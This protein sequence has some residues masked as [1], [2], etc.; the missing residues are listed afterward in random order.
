MGTTANER[1]RV[2]YAAVICA[3]VDALQVAGDCDA[4]ELVAAMGCKLELA[5]LAGRVSRAA[6]D[7]YTWSVGAVSLSAGRLLSAPGKMPG[8]SFS[9]PA[10]QSCPGAAVA[11]RDAERDGVGDETTCVVCY[12]KGGFYTFKSTREALAARF[13]FVRESLRVDAGATFVAAMVV[14]IACEVAR[15]G[16]PCFRV[17]DAGDVYSAAYAACWARV[18]RALPGVRFWVP[19]R[20]YVRPV[21]RA[22]MRDLA[23]LANVAVRPSAIFRDGSVPDLTREGFAPG[24]GVAPSVDA[25]RP[26]T[27]I[28]PATVAGNTPTCEANGCRMCWAKDGAP[29]QGFPWTARALPVV[30]IAH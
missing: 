26:D 7:R 8:A 9:L 27:W 18:A 15:T 16:E 23:N 19:T 20:E 14:A 4:A 22:A 12:A 25:V 21:M 10:G 29:V 28:C 24:S 6:V 2:E 13:A 5:G 3:C 11:Q 1:T 17:H 30:Y